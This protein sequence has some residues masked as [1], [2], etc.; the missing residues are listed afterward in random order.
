MPLRRPPIPV[1]FRLLAGLLL[2]SQAGCTSALTTAA[3]REALHDA[4]DSVAAVG[5]TDAAG[6]DRDPEGL[7]GR[8]T[9]GPADEP[10]RLI[11]EPKPPSLDESVNQAVVRLKSA[12]EL[13]AQTQAT[14]LSILEK[15]SPEDWPAAIDAFAAS[16]EAYR[17]PPRVSAQA[18]VQPA[19]AQPA[20][21][22]THTEPAAT[23]EFPASAPLGDQ[24]H[25]T[26]A[27]PAAATV[28]FEP[29]AEP[30]APLAAEQ[31]A[32]MQLVFPGMPLVFP[33][34]P[35]T[36]EPARLA[37]IEAARAGGPK[38]D[39]SA[40][41]GLV[42]TEAADETV[43]PSVAAERITLPEPPLT[44]P[45]TP[46]PQVVAAPP[47]PFEPPVTLDI[48]AVVEGNAVMPPAKPAPPALT[49][50]NANF[51]SRVRAWGVVEK[52]PEAVFRP[53]QDVIVYF[54][55]DAL[56]ARQSPSGHTS[57]VD[58]I[59]RLFDSDGR[60]VSH[61]DFEPIDETS[62]TPRREYFARYFIRIP[63]TAA[64]GPHRLELMITD[65]V[66]D[67]SSHAHLELEVRR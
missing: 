19:A 20:A 50:R 66:A 17:P 55:L 67:V 9:D 8:A 59:F 38:P 16:L 47:K 11:S 36:P 46:E 10:T 27:E 60:E 26:P 21:R 64:A 23:L 48:P 25:E 28:A 61:W 7:A 4:V 40:E 52:F 44:Q 35:I 12:G 37:D 5:A 42:F 3:M 29:P 41:D 22:V 13:D 15:T 62:P 63:E 56:T 32:D 39:E 6:S 58:T 45:A 49:V 31:Q 18:P 30:H 33:G 2:L 54:E 43:R 34:M 24:R 1:V 14:L 65:L 57:R 51:V 53:G